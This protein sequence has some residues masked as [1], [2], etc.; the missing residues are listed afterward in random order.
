[1]DTFFFCRQCFKLKYINKDLGNHGNPA[2]FFTLSIFRAT[3][4]E[5][6]RD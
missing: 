5:M 6:K 3:V 4:R 1:M 2:V